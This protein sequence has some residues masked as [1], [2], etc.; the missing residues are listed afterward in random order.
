M[1]SIVQGPSPNELL[2]NIIPAQVDKMRVDLAGLNHCAE[3]FL[4]SADATIAG[5]VLY[6]PQYQMKSWR[7]A[8]KDL[9]KRVKNS[10]IVNTIIIVISIDNKIVDQEVVTIYCKAESKL[11]SY[12][13][14]IN[15]RHKY[16]K[17]SY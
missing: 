3:P 8:H 16:P 17:K 11:S 1:D 2:S 4:S 12:Y 9:L 6:Q 15:Q 10:N 5:I 14:D 13:I 7:T